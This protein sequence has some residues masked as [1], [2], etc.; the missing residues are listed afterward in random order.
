MPR[1]RNIKPSLFKNELLGEADPLLTIL[2]EGLWCLAD[3][4][5]RL[6]DRP[7]RI[8][9]EIFPYREIPD[10]NRYLTVLEQLGFIHRYTVNNHP[11]IHVIN[12][13][14]HQSPHKTEKQSIIPKP[15]IKSDSCPLT[16]TAPL[17]TEMVKVKESLI[18]DSGYLIPDSSNTD[19][20]TADSG[21]LINSEKEA[22]NKKQATK[23]AKEARKEIWEE[24]SKAYFVRYATDPVRNA[25]VNTAVKQIHERIGKEAKYVVAFYVTIND[26]FLI[27]QSHALG[28]LLQN[29]EGYVTQWRRGQA[30]T[31]TSARQTDQSQSNFDAAEQAIALRRSRNANRD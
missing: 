10:F 28:P 25:K 24:Y 5:G 26:Q 30:V 21:P 12:F 18:P 31:T 19:L 1:S 27:K 23:E 22:T 16:D 7:K 2:F 29:C 3:R 13:A 11:Y 6:E 17:N 9:A 15:P 14:I 4:E 8:K 20:L